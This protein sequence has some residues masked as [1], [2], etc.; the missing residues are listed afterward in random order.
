MTFPAGLTAI[1]ANGFNSCTGLIEIIF[2]DAT[3]PTLAN[4]AFGDEAQMAKIDVIVPNGVSLNSDS[5]W[6]QSPWTLFKSVT[7]G[8]LPTGLEQPAV[9]GENIGIYSS[10]AAAEIRL[11]GLEGAETVR[12]YDINGREVLKA[13]VS[14]QNATI[15]VAALSRG[16]Y[17]LKTESGVLK[18]IKQ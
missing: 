9:S 11:Y 3:P 5:P 16:V 6:K 13:T 2:K 4:L 15:P 14:T 10:A 8:S 12:I 18:F 1:D 17:L 7:N